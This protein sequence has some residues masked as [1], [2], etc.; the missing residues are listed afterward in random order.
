MSGSRAI[1]V[2]VVFVL[3]MG[4]VVLIN[5]QGSETARRKLQQQGV[6]F[7]D[8]A[9]I[10]SIRKGDEK[11]VRL[12]LDAGMNPNLRETTESGSTALM[13][14]AVDG[15]TDILKALLAHGADVNAQNKSGATALIF[16]LSE[17]QIQTSL[18]LLATKEIDVK[19]RRND[20]S[21]ALMYAVALGD[22]DLVRTVLAK[23]ADPNTSNKTGFTVLM[24]AASKGSAEVVKALLEKG[25]NIDAEDKGK[26]TALLI[27]EKEG[28][29]DVVQVLVDNGAGR[30]PGKNT[31]P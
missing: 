2:V 22:A 15:R 1:S 11:T 26:M 27:A 16:A 23:G 8:E 20:G 14:A 17:R 6:A 5:G 7:T 19:L 18:D 12:F 30:K 29:P 21:N 13:L 28:H 3:L 24:F 25:A 10:A 4:I 9:F 31:W